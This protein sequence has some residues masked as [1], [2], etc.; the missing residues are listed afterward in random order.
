MPAVVHV[1]I[2]LIIAGM[3]LVELLSITSDI[4][5]IKSSNSVASV[6]VAGLPLKS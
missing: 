5:V 2:G 1:M 3:P 4:I 6:A